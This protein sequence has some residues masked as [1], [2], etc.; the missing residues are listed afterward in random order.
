MSLL[1]QGLLALTL[2]SPQEENARPQAKKGV[3]R[4]EYDF[5]EY[6]SEALAALSFRLENEKRDFD[7]ALASWRQTEEAAGK[8]KRKDLVTKSQL[9]EARCL[10]ALGRKDEAKAVWKAVIA[11][12]PKNAEATEALAR[13]DAPAQDDAELNEIVRH[14]CEIA[15]SLKD[16]QSPERVESARVDLIRMSD[17][18][19]PQLADLL[20]DNRVGVVDGAAWILA[21]MQTGRAF[22]ALAAALRDPA[23]RY[24]KVLVEKV[25]S[26]GTEAALPFFEAMVERPEQEFRYDGENRLLNELGALPVEAQV[27]KILRLLGHP[28]ERMRTEAASHRFGEET[29]RRLVPAFESLLASNEEP[30]LRLAATFLNGNRESLPTAV[31]ERWSAQL[32]RCPIASIRAW[33]LRSDWEVADKLRTRSGDLRPRTAALLR[34]LSDGDPTLFVEG[35]VRI[36]NFGRFQADDVPAGSRAGLLAALNLALELP[37]VPLTKR[38][39]VLSQLPLEGLGDDE[40][41]DLFV[42]LATKPQEADADWRTSVRERFAQSLLRRKSENDRD[43]YGASLLLK[44]PDAVG[45]RVWF[46]STR[47]RNGGLRQSAIQAV[48]SGDV[49]LRRLGYVELAFGMRAAEMPHAVEDLGSADPAVVLAAVKAIGW[50]EAPELVAPLRKLLARESS[51]ELHDAALRALANVGGK[52]VADELLAAMKATPK[53]GEFRY[54]RQLEQA[55]GAERLAQELVAVARAHGTSNSICGWMRIDN[56]MRVSGECASAFVRQ[57]PPELV[58][59]NVLD[60]LADQLEPDV[61]ASLVIQRLRDGKGGEVAS[62]ARLAGHYH[63]EAAWSALVRL[64]D[65]G[66]GQTREEAIAALKQLRDY[67]ELRRS[68]TA[69]D[70]SDARRDA[71]E[72]AKAMAKSANAEQRMGATIA[73]AAIGDVAAIP[74]LLEMLADSDRD[75]RVAAKKALEK[76]ADRAVVQ[77]AEAPKSGDEKS[78]GDEKGKKK[79]Q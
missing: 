57:L 29:V 31:A 35:A 79:Q 54:L 51:G 55:L 15:L 2:V 39:T 25:C 76:L 60:L 16:N 40:I 49:E 46:A 56:G 53:D 4:T 13:L 77:P 27:E 38:Y 26:V 58:G 59:S 8:E 10:K 44:I 72:K 28:D 61:L 73:L 62:A 43:A 12:D 1:A 75:V 34:F 69:D 78:G 74:T 18:A 9:G 64:L 42:R 41:F 70:D 19:V 63:I 3:V 7:A 20:R 24:P 32:A 71:L 22:D 23:C 67:R 30:S 11:A 68:F 6:A 52:E 36:E 14:R 21:Q 66:V 37:E 45:R 65:T 5:V 47:S 17:V 33:Q 50:G 48:K